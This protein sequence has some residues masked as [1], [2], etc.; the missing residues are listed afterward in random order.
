M[1][2]VHQFQEFPK[3]TI[4]IHI[5]LIGENYHLRTTNTHKATEVVIKMEENFHLFR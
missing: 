4:A 1:L 2:N 3:R 5:F